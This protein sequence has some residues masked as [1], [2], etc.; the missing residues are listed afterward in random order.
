MKSERTGKSESAQQACEVGSESVPTARNERMA[1]VK[2][3]GY[4]QLRA[5]ARVDLRHCHTTKS[6]RRPASC[7]KAHREQLRHEA[8]DEEEEIR[9][10][11]NEVL[12]K[13]LEL[14]LILSERIV[15]I[16]V[17]CNYGNEVFE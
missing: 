7:R 1:D 13:R 4:G 11:F 8:R 6:G 14:L 17:S 5:R 16:Q 10:V 15:S 3:D 2:T 9:E 12:G